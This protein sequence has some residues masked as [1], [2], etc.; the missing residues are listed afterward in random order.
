VEIVQ[1]AP[2]Q[3]LPREAVAR[4][5]RPAAVAHAAVG[6]VEL[7]P[8]HAATAGQR[9]AHAA[10][11]IVDQIVQRAVDR[12][13]GQRSRLIVLGGGRRAAGSRDLLVGTD[14]LLILCYMPPLMVRRLPVILAGYIHGRI[15]R[16]ASGGCEF[17]GLP[18]KKITDHHHTPEEDWQ[19]EDAEQICLPNTHH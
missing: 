13:G 9:H 6:I 18:Q 3:P 11:I 19:L 4:R 15:S 16:L 7:H 2:I 14:V 10:Q 12:L 5:Q 1:P 17:I 8:L